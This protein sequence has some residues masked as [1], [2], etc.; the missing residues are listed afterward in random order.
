[1]TEERLE[2]LLPRLIRKLRLESP[3]EDTMLLLEDELRDAED[4]LLLYLGMETLPEQFCTKLVELAS[5]YY[6]RDACASEYSG[7]KSRSYS[8]GD[9]SQ[10]ATLATASDYEEA[11][12]RIFA[13]LA[14]HRRVAVRHWG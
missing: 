7:E 10:S 11:A 12:Q 1:M 2:E 4:G 6:Q 5:V 3:D 9:I 13:S 8:E 14:A